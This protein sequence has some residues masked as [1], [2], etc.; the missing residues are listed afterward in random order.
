MDNHDL[1][2]HKKIVLELSEI[3]LARI[4]D[5]LYLEHKDDFVDY[6]NRT[7]K[8]GWFKEQIKAEYNKKIK[9]IL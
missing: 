4:I 8:L 3:T 7:H 5:D 1:I 6:Q 9:E 2:E